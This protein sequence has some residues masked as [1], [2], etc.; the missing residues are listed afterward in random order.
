MEDTRLKVRCRDGRV[1]AVCSMW[2]RSTC[3]VQLKG[4]VYYRL[5]NL[6]DLE[7]IEE[8]EYRRAK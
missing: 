6:D 4:D 2:T 5:E 3:S 7:P 8:D 1:A